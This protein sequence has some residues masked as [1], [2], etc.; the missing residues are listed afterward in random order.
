[1]ALRRYG[2]DDFDPAVVPLDGTETTMVRQGGQ[3]VTVTVSD[4]LTGTGVM[5]NPMTGPGDLILGGVAGAPLRLPAGSTSE[6]LS[7]DVSGL[8]V[9]RPE[10]GF[11]SPMTMTGDLIVGGSGGTP[12]RLGIG[13]EDQVLK[14]QSG[15]PVWAEDEGMVNPMTTAGQLVVGGVGGDPAALTVGSTGQVLRVVGGMPV[16]Q[17]L[18]TA[19][20]AAVTDFAPA[21]HGHAAANITDSTTAG[22]AL[23]TAADAA[24]QRASL[25]LGTAA[26]EDVGDFAP[27][28]HTHALS[29]LTQS[30]ATT[31]QVIEWNGT[32]WVPATPSSGGM[33]NPMTTAGDIIVGGASGAPSRLGAGTDG[34]VL[35][36]VA[37]V[38]SWE[39]PAA[40]STASVVLPITGATH[41]LD[42]ADAGKY[43]RFT[44]ASAKT[45]NIRTDATHALPANGEWEL[46][47]AGTLDLTIVPAG[48]VT[49]NVPAGGTL[50]LEPGMSAVL[51]RAAADVFDLIGH[52][53]AA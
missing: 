37:G 5:L 35:T 27:V 36:L 30:G 1:M 16:W 45:L 6:V 51:K 34:E 18:G 10:T 7:I 28:S 31:G 26:L 4:L 53:K 21:V 42:A 20:D 15:A 9:W 11:A 41:D 32:A 52:T 17:T 8:L 19:A 48:G 25:G 23:L 43:H 47:N 46:R 22:R 13:T 14:V 38:P 40:P 2:T 12:A 44:S 49:V 50:V 29:D 39:T 33:T 3:Q 24:A